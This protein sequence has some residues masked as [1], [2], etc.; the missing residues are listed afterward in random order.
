MS[1]IFSPAGLEKQKR[2]IA[3]LTARMDKLKIHL[4]EIAELCGDGFHDNFM[5]EQSVIQVADLEHRINEEKGIL[6]RAVI[7]LLPPASNDRVAIGHKIRAR[8]GGREIEYIIGGYGESDPAANTLAYD[9]PIAKTI[10]GAR[11]GD[12]CEVEFGPKK[13]RIEILEIV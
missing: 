1:K 7:V 12:I 13:S 8:I 11:V 9:T 4:A 6:E 3:D 5:F 10:I 2:L